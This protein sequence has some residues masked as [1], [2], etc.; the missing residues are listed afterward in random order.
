MVQ[1]RTGTIVSVSDVDPSWFPSY[2]V[3]DYAYSF[4]LINY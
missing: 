3:P 2:T 1:A 4:D